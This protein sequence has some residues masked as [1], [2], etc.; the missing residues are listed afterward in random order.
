MPDAP[1]RIVSLLAAS[2]EM[3]FAVGAQGQVVGVSHECNY[4]AAALQL[5]RVSTTAIDSTATSGTIDEQVKACVAAGQALYSIDR[6]LLESLA[7][8]LIVTQAQC[9]VCAIRYEDVVDAVNECDRL[10]DTAVLALNPQSLSDI[11]ADCRRVGEA[12]GCASQAEHFVESLHKRIDTIAAK[13]APLSA[14]DRPRVAVIE[15]TDPPMLAANWTPELVDL[16]GGQCDLAVAGKH[17]TYVDW[18]Q[19][20]AFDPEVIVV[21]PCGFDLTRTLVEAEHLTQLDGWSNLAAVRTGRV[22]AVDGDAFFNRAGPRIVDS[23]EI[24]AYAVHPERFDEPRQ[25]VAGKDWQLLSHV[26]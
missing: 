11:L 16:A 8:D 19:V 3:L 15:W 21:T 6:S 17:S 1:A 10:R 18:Q 2:T 22:F 26:S 7:P 13:T 12:A 20:V 5:P 9:D 25:M 23:L 24:L 14:A 4:P